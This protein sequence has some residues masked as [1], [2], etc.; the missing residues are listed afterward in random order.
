M[1]L[2]W[3]LWG[4]LLDAAAAKVL[5]GLD[6][7]RKTVTIPRALAAN[8]PRLKLLLDALLLTVAL[9]LA[10]SQALEELNLV[11][12]RVYP[13]GGSRL[14]LKISLQKLLEAFFDS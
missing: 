9:C 3:L 2:S 4:C 11:D 6:S 5:K 7:L 13:C 14:I 8:A 1:V 12:G 10:L